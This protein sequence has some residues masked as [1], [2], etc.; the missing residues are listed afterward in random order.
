METTHAILFAHKSATR[1]E[2]KINTVQSNCPLKVWMNVTDAILSTVHLLLV[3]LKVASVLSRQFVT[4]GVEL[5][6]G[7]CKVQKQ[8]GVFSKL[9]SIDKLCFTYCEVLCCKDIK[10]KTLINMK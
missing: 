6:E 5:G 1:V 7:H 9:Q 4:I 3:K 10:D 2:M 8:V